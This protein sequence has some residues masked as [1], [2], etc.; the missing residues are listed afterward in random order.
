MAIKKIDNAN[1][2]SKVAWFV[3][4]LAL[5]L[6]LVLFNK[7][8]TTFFGGAGASDTP[9][10]LTVT[11]EPEFQAGTFDRTKTAA[12]DASDDGHVEL[13]FGFGTSL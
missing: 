1:Q 12:D 8:L 3:L 4:G 10:Q 7:Q 11:T 13:D 5:V 2:S 9:R 6:V